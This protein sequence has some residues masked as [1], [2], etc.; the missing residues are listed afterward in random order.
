MRLASKGGP[1]S[2]GYLKVRQ[3]TDVYGQFLYHQQLLSVEQNSNLSKIRIH[4]RIHIWKHFLILFCTF[5]CYVIVLADQIWTERD[6]GFYLFYI[7][8]ICSDPDSY[9]LQDKERDDF[10]FRPTNKI[11]LSVSR[12]ISWPV[13]TELNHV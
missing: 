1:G 5:L 10:E 13:A 11:D 7:D 8:C 12:L 4:F 9:L 6:L 3:L 2:I